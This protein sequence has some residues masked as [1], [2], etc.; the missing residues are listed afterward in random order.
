MCF[1]DRLAVAGGCCLLLLGPRPLVRDAALLALQ[2]LE[3]GAAARRAVL[4]LALQARELLR[5]LLPALRQ[6]R[7]ARVRFR[8]GA[9]SRNP[10]PVE[11]TSN[12]CLGTAIKVRRVS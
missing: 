1:R 8:P 7:R 12:T 9:W 3:E 11:D 4:L 10:F 2:V 5:G 6:V